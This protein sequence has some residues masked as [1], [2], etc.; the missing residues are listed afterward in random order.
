MLLARWILTRPKVLI[1]DEPTR[2]IDVGAKFEIAKLMAELC[3][4]GMAVLFIS[5]EL[6]EIV[7]S[8][9]RVAVLRDHHVVGEL[10]GPAISESAIMATIA[11]G[12]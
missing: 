12:G 4:G 5:S 8:C 6:D 2:G 10:A 3:G 9:Q 1:L 7:R 11:A